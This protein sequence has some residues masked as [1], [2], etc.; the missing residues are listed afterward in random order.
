MKNPRN[1]LNL[2]NVKSLG[3]VHAQAISKP[4]IFL[5]SNHKEKCFLWDIFPCGFLRLCKKEPPVA[6]HATAPLQMGLI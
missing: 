3:A 6:F 2:I 1:Y 5:I 4:Q